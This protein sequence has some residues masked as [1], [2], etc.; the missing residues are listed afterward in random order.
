MIRIE[1]RGHIYHYNH[2]E[3]DL[4]VDSEETCSVCGREK[5][6]EVYVM[7]MKSL[8]EKGLLPNNE[9]L[10]CCFC[11]KNITRARLI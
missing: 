8:K 3:R 2:Q 7:I 5:L 10:I 6:D 9:P 11:R 4:D 1:R